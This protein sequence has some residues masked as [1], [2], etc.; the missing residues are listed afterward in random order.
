MPAQPV[1]S[2]IDSRMS[3]LKMAAKLKIPSSIMAAT[4]VSAESQHNRKN[5]DFT[6]YHLLVGVTR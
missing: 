5:G 6:A 2:E 3:A 4:D 1:Q